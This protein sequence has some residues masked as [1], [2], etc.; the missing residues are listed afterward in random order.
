[1]KQ[2]PLT[3]GLSALVDDEDYEELMKF[4]WCA[5]SH[6]YAKRDEGGR[7]SKRVIYMHRVVARAMEGDHV[8]HINGNKLDN[9]R[10]NLRIC[11]HQENC[12][13]RGVQSNNTSGAKGVSLLKSTGR[14]MARIKQYGKSKYL[15][16]FATPEEANAAYAKAAKEH[17][18][19]F[20]RS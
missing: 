8:D 14:Y 17:F 15:G 5:H 4:K 2:I 7:K 19:E 9:T 11:T 10:A 13:N 12:C 3:K 1:M 20:S 6:G 16:V 18:G